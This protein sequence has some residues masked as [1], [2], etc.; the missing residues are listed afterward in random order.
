MAD[1][2]KK[3]L[4][5]LNY[6]NNQ[7]KAWLV[8]SLFVAL[9]VFGII[10][11]WHMIE[12]VTVMWLVGSIGLLIS[13]TWWYWTMRLIRNLLEFKI[14]EARLLVEIVTDLKE[15]KENISNKP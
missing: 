3:H 11:E 9:A 10:L 14:E 2:F 1:L 13:V 8:L 15:I 5:Q 4:E 12:S 6:F 7:R